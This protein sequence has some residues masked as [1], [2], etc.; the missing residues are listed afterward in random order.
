MNYL[1]LQSNWILEQWEIKPLCFPAETLQLYCS[2]LLGIKPNLQSKGV[3]HFP[4]HP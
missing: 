4:K 2:L 1:R 3:T